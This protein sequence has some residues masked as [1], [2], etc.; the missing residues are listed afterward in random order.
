MLNR[1]LYR[2]LESD[3]EYMVSD[4][5]VEEAIKGN[6]YLFTKNGETANRIAALAE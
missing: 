2:G 1:Y 6:D 4:A 5:N 3:Y